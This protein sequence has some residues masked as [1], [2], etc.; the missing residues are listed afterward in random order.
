MVAMAGLFFVNRCE[1]LLLCGVVF[2]ALSAASGLPWRF[3]VRGMRLVW[4]LALFTFVFNLFLTPGTPLFTLGGITATWE[5]FWNGS[6][7]ALRFFL[8]VL[9]TSLLSLTTSPILLTDAIENMLSVFKWTGLPAHELALVGTIALRFV[10][11]LAQEAERIMK[12]QLARGACLDRGTYATRFRALLSIMVPLFVSAFRYAE[13]LALAMESRCYRG[14]ARRTRVHE[15]HFRGADFWA[16]LLGVSFIV[17][18]AVG[19]WY[20]GPISLSPFG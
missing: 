19:N 14:G 6:A 10:P 7:M 8:L 11:T 1:L 20:L 4:I 15:L 16:L 13:D 9:I 2:L 3:L 18:L 17:S 12:A 5:G